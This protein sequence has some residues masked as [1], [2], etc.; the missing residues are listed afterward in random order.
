MI[1][2]GNAEDGPFRT[3]QV[4]LW[5]R[6]TM[7]PAPLSRAKVETLGVTRTRLAAKSYEGPLTRSASAL[8]PTG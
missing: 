8:T 3:N 5:V 7:H 4:D 1:A 2:P 6:G